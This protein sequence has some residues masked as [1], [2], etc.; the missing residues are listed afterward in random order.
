MPVPS[1]PSQLS[2]RAGGLPEKPP[3]PLGV[4]TRS[5]SRTPLK[6]LSIRKSSNNYPEVIHAGFKLFAAAD[7]PGLSKLGSVKP[8]QD[9]IGDIDVDNSASSNLN[10][11]MGTDDPSS[12]VPASQV[13][14]SDP[15]V[16]HG[17]NSAQGKPSFPDLECSGNI[18]FVT[19]D[20]L[21][22]ICANTAASVYE[23]M[24]KIYEGG[25]VAVSIKKLSQEFI[26]S[27]LVEAAMIAY[28]S[29]ACIS[30]EFVN[31]MKPFIAY[32]ILN[33]VFEAKFSKLLSY[34]FK[35]KEMVDQVCLDS[36]K[37]VKR[38]EL[39][40][41][42]G[43]GGL[44]YSSDGLQSPFCSILGESVLGEIVVE[45][46]PGTGKKARSIVVDDIMEEKVNNNGSKVKQVDT[47]R[48][49]VKILEAKG[50][51]RK[52]A[53]NKD[54]SGG[55]GGFQPMG[56]RF[57]A[58]KNSLYNACFNIGRIVYGTEKPVTSRMV[59]KMIEV[60]VLNK[61]ANEMEDDGN[62]AASNGSEPL[63]VKI[64]KKRV[65][66]RKS[67]KEI[68]E[69]L[70][71]KEQK[72]K[73]EKAELVNNVQ[74]IELVNNDKMSGGVMMFKAGESKESTAVREKLMGIGK[75][76]YAA[77]T[78]GVKSKE[79]ND[80]IKFTPPTMMEN[81]ELVVLVEPSIVEKA[82]YVYNNS[83][84]GYFVGSY[85]RL[86]FVRFNLYKMWKKFGIKDISS[87][88]NG[89]FYFKFQSEGGMEEVLKAGPWIV[90]NIPLCLKKWEPA[91]CLSKPEPKS[92]P[93]WVVL[94]NLPL[95]LW[96]TEWI[97]KVVS[98]I[99]NP[100]TFDNATKFRC[101]NSGGA[102]GFAR[103]LV[104]IEVKEKFPDYVKT[105]Y[106]K[107]GEMTN[108]EI[109]IQVEYHG[110]PI[111]CKHCKVF[112][113]LYDKCSMRPMTED[114][115]KLHEDNQ[116]KVGSSNGK[117][118]NVDEDGFQQASK[119]FWNVRPPAKQQ[120][121]GSWQR[122]KGP[123][124]T[125]IGTQWQ[126]SGRK[127]NYTQHTVVNP[128]TGQ[129]HENLSG[130]KKDDARNI[131]KAGGVS[132][133][134]SSGG[135]GKSG[136]FG[137]HQQGKFSHP[138]YV[139]VNN[140]GKNA[141]RGDQGVKI[142]NRFNGLEQLGEEDTMLNDVHKPEV[143][144][145]PN[146]DKDSIPPLKEP[147]KIFL[148][149]PLTVKQEAEVMVVFNKRVAPEVGVFGKWS[150]AQCRYFKWLCLDN[151]F[152]EGLKHMIKED[153]S[154]DEEVESET[155]ESAKFLFK[156]IKGESAVRKNHAQAI[157]IN[158]SVTAPVLSSPVVNSVF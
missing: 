133:N 112:G 131:D 7:D 76:S 81:G 52:T 114:E 27:E 5:R 93:V 90:N 105:I 115:K 68:L 134:A 150:D 22:D 66:V 58:L 147:K 32:H 70:K 110:M 101:A 56:S 16:K 64:L 19:K 108:K 96:N 102:G 43:I 91:I 67:D 48:K 120:N 98:C 46:Q 23:F 113:H 39:T 8:D 54:E 26:S 117:T 154:M 109:L 138:K 118:V 129:I 31:I 148:G 4:Q 156:G 123:A 3:D 153:E 61:E 155:D 28:L 146:R 142:Q 116:N 69:D 141:V 89:V 40:G 57:F 144:N 87:N 59:T 136:N 24:H 51:S 92:V 97:C 1:N 86:D 17:K 137:L 15:M 62:D 88:G 42:E 132:Y 33:P 50:K 74:G 157:G 100:I 84:Y 106:L 152:V 149:V 10:D 140:I 82:K 122:N 6:E 95:E 128:S 121:N 35:V 145:V 72:I 36:G 126:Q 73:E 124:R 30:P 14:N 94:K 9:S 53:V 130:K 125:N 12:F 25:V 37:Y 13:L 104:E 65:C 60:P 41:Q 139:K 79:F 55:D 151:D 44:L 158:G 49:V 21:N 135:I 143:E 119:R 85:V 34:E 45:R 103:V 47:Q 29:R 111:N 11:S 20:N 71:W 83:L 127:V 99:G 78:S 63:T 75:S 80:S 2:G 107:E 77:A 38:K 18:I